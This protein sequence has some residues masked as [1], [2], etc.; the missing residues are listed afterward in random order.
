MS[1][2]PSNW[3]IYLKDTGEPIGSIGF[4]RLDY[5]SGIGEIGFILVNRYAGRGYMTEACQAV[6]SFGLGEMGLNTVE[7]KVTL[8]N[9]ASVRIFQKIG[10]TKQGRIR[11]RLSSKGPEMEMDLYAIHSMNATGKT[12]NGEHPSEDV[13]LSQ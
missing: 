8:D 3:K 2:L 11:S 12:S 13:Q 5:A 7:A 4:F 10:M 6:V 9:P 1:G